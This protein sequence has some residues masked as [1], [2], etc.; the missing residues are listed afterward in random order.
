MKAGVALNAPDPA[1]FYTA[2]A[3]GYTDYP[4]AEALKAVATT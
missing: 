3:K 4:R 2:D 1:T